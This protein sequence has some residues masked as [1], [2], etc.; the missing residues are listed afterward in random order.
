MVEISQIEL[1]E[2]RSRPGEWAL[3]A[4]SAYRY[5]Q[6]DQLNL[7][8]VR[9][10]AAI[11]IVYFLGSG[12][13][14][15]F[16]GQDRENIVA[17]YVFVVPPG[18]PFG[19]VGEKNG[20]V[21]CVHIQAIGSP[22]VGLALP[23]K[24]RVHSPAV[25]CALLDMA[26]EYARTGAVTTSL[27]GLF[28]ALLNGRSA[29]RVTFA[30]HAE[31]RPPRDTAR[32]SHREEHQIDYYLKAKGRFWLADRWH[33][34]ADGHL[35]YIPPGVEHAIELDPTAPYHNLSL[36][37]IPDE[38]LQGQV[39][40]EAARIE[41]GDNAPELRR[42]M[43]QITASYLLYAPVA[44]GEVG[45]VL[46]LVAEA[47]EAA[48][49]AEGGSRTHARKS[50]VDL[51]RQIVASNY[52]LPI[53]LDWVARRL[54]LSPAYL[55]RAFRERAGETF[56][57]HLRR[58]RVARA[59]ALL[60]ESSL[61]VGEIARQCGFATIHYFSQTFRRETGHTPTDVRRGRGGNA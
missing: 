61:T 25:S 7:P 13:D 19:I 60:R 26:A 2:S 24:V 37:F 9:L 3:S 59:A 28:E 16:F 6:R 33:E 48:E 11:Q 35:F 30:D 18:M 4:A 8:S 47:A 20:A 5:F 29:V 39:R 51:A 15:F 54:G 50:K 58:V 10:P 12:A 44:S 36:K 27:D 38:A 40:G 53:R 31:G 57:T 46:A 32:H 41:A 42:A 17:D 22:P 14:S 52:S 34:I 45:R 55:S 49:A 43:Q 23:A 21:D 56:S 1:P